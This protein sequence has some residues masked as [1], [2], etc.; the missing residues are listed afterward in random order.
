MNVWK[1]KV[2]YKEWSRESMVDYPH[3]RRSRQCQRARQHEHSTI[4]PLWI[5]GTLKSTLVV[6][7][8]EAPFED[9]SDALANGSVR[10]HCSLGQNN[11]PLVD[12]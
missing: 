6:L 9:G 10:R 3:S 7:V 11:P 8:A 1:K 4:R 5:M 12:N 2:R